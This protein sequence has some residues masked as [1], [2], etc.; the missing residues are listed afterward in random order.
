[1]FVCA[2]HFGENRAIPRVYCIGV[3]LASLSAKLFR[4]VPTQIT[5]F[6]KGRRGNPALNPHDGGC[7]NG[8]GESSATA[9]FG[10]FACPEVANNG[11]TV[12]PSGMTVTV[13]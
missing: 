12:S 2:L 1:M 5:G 3:G 10:A 11:R 6:G 4:H 13:A 9:G 7:R 8:G